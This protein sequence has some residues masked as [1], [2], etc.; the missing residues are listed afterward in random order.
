MIVTSF[1][2][3]ASINFFHD[4]LL[5]FIHHNKNK[6]LC[7]NTQQK[8]DASPADP[9]PRLSQQTNQRSLLH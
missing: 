6:K 5:L 7:K 2:L 8:N 3:T 4:A 9:D 1:I